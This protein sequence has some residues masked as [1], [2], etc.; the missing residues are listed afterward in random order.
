MRITRF[1]A[2]V[3]EDRIRIARHGL[4]PRLTSVLEERSVG[5]AIDQREDEAVIRKEPLHG[6]IGSPIADLARD[7]EA[8]LI[9][10]RRLEIV[11]QHEQLS[12]AGRHRNLRQ[13]L[14]PLL[15]EDG[16]PRDARAPVV[17]ITKA[18]RRLFEIQSDG[19][20]RS[21]ARFE[22]EQLEQVPVVRTARA[23]VD[24][25]LLIGVDVVREPDPRR[26]CVGV[27]VTVVAGA[28][29]VVCIETARKQ[30]IRPRLLARDSRIVGE[31]RIDEVLRSHEICVG[32]VFLVIPTYAHVDDEVL[33]H[34]PIVLDVEA[35]LFGIGHDRGALTGDIE[36]REKVDTIRRCS[37]AAR[38]HLVAEL[39]IDRARV[40][41]RQ[42]DVLVTHAR[43]HGVLPDPL[44]ARK[45]QVVHERPPILLADLRVTAARRPRVDEDP[46]V[47]Y[48]PAR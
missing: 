24:H 5:I 9:G 46:L 25:V 29:E 38:R 39:R 45:G 36:R 1:D 20:K 10:V 15:Q 41:R 7:P 22:G 6:D 40:L 43:L 28:H 31:E 32:W 17:A 26:P 4:A 19:R 14:D 18:R 12:A 34:F 37:D 48:E 2:V 33:V 42:L 44:E 35:V 11:V 3:A 13:R 23:A 47:L 21:L 27:V 16:I 8:V 30:S